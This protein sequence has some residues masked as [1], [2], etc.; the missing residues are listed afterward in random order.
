MLS[1]RKKVLYTILTSPFAY[2][3]YKANKWQI[4]RKQEKIIEIETR[5]HRL[6]ETPRIL[7]R[8]TINEF[9]MSEE[10]D[11]RPVQLIGH[12]DADKRLLINKTKDSEPGYHLVSPF[13]CYKDE[14][15]NEKALL[16]DRGWIPSDYRLDRLQLD[17]NRESNITGIIYKGDTFNKYSKITDDSCEAM[18][19]KLFYMNPRELALNLKLD[20]PIASQFIIKVVDFGNQKKSFKKQFPLL[21]KKDDLMV[22]TISPEKHQSYAN[23]WISVTVF[24]VV[25]NIFVWAYL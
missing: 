18:R 16:V 1:F 6:E 22:W 19:N 8:E 5:E 12:F 3:T 13:Y 15:G 4:R 20:N 11:F 9:K 21:I 24:N 23:F 10:W 2:V 7:D 25:S 14:Q 17:Y